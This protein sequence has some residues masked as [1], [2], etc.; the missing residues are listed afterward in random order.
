MAPFA[1]VGYA[2]IKEMLCDKL[3]EELEFRKITT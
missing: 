3:V 2:P 1:P